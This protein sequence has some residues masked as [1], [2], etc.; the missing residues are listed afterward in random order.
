MK[1]KLIALC[2]SSKILYRIYFSVMSFFLSV[3]KLFVK[4]DDALILINSFGGKKFDDS[5]KAIYDHLITD[6]RFKHCKFVW[7]FHAP[8]QFDVPVGAKIKTDTMKYYITALKARVWISNSGIERG[9]RFKG[10]RTFYY[11]SWHGTPI[12][13]MGNDVPSNSKSSKPLSIS[14]LIDVFS[15]QSTYEADKLSKAFGVPRDK[16]IITGL[17]RNDELAACGGDAIRQQKKQLLGIDPHKKVILFAPTYRE[18]TKN[19]WGECIT[20]WPIDF[21]AL[22]K[23]LSDQ[24]VLI[25]RAHY[26]SVQAVN[27]YV[28]NAFVYDFSS[29]PNLND[30]MLASDVLVSDYSSLIFDYSILDRPIICFAYD[31]ET[32]AQNRGMYFDIRQ[33]LSDASE[34]DTALRSKIRELETASGMDRNLALVKSFREKYVEAYGSACRQVADLLACRITPF[35][36]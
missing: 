3:I 13:I 19:H 5:P 11:N 1:A 4:P 2:K 14:V 29:Y 10:K 7:A 31:Y 15:A 35:E 22:K 26:E 18:Y 36:K 23:E 28:D 24:Y 32:Y 6:V 34:S 20:A 33:E 17:P 8:E 9:L 30:L 27:E 25:L 12:K 16:Y 21:D